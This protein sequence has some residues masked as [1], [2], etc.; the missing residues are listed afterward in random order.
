MEGSII[1]VC[2]KPSSLLFPAAIKRE[3]G[4]EEKGRRDGGG[5]ENEKKRRY[6]TNFLLTTQDVTLEEAAMS[7]PVEEIRK[8]LAMEDLM[9]YSADSVLRCA[10]LFLFYKCHA[11]I[12]YTLDPHSPRFK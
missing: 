6:N 3:G 1:M 4:R 5:R 10:L 2:L 12:A 11:C 7:L 8:L 9:A